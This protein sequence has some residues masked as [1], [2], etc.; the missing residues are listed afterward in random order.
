MTEYY[1]T[2]SS[3]VL[4]VHDMVIWN[5]DAQ[6]TFYEFSFSVISM[7]K[8]VFMCDMEIPNDKAVSTKVRQNC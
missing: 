6:F 8:I 5:K 2:K 3:E 4:R 1:M 7:Q